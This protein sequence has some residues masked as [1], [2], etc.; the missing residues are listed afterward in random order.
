MNDEQVG[1]M[2]DDTQQYR[3]HCTIDAD[4]VFV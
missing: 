2:R 3:A 1:I 4:P